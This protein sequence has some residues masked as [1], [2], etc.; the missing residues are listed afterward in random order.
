MATKK[1]APKPGDPGY[2]KW[3]GTRGGEATKKNKPKNYFSK[4]ATK[5]HE[6]RDKSTYRG[7]RK[8]RPQADVV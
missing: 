2:M 6:T 1:K 4:I 5:S 7:G 8:P 3:L